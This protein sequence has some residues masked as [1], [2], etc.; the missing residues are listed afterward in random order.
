M[1]SYVVIFKSKLKTLLILVEVLLSLSYITLT[2][3]HLADA[4]I[5]SDLQ[6]GNT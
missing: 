5:Q 6:L 2:F 4:F 1:A 3:S